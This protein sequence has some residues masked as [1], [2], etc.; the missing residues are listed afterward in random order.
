MKRL[1]IVALVGLPILFIAACASPSHPVSENT[2]GRSVAPTH[3]SAPARAAR[4]PAL[5]VVPTGIPFGQRQAIYDPL[6]RNLW[7]LTRADADNAVLLTSVASADG[8]ARTT[9]L[10]ADGADWAAGSLTMHEGRVWASW[11]THLVSFSPATGLVRAV[12]VPWKDRGNGTVGR[13]TAMTAAGKCLWIGVI[14][15][16]R[17][18]CYEPSASTWRAVSTPEGRP[19]S[20][21]TKM[22]SSGTSALVNL[23]T[24]AATPTL[25]TGGTEIVW[26]PE[27]TVP[28]A[29]ESTSTT[30]V[31]GNSGALLEGP[32]TTA[33]AA[34]SAGAARPRPALRHLARL[35]AVSG[36]PAV[37]L[38]PPPA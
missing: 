30:G 20:F 12:T 19:V 5:K 13:S 24:P 21:F 29:S 32:D 33:T 3:S 17:L 14:G 11:G 4:E 34:P 7:V 38:I 23:G 31:V 35:S 15:E 1:P 6:A 18:R 37:T 2:Y 27:N 22:A 9:K 25:P 36:R 28:V 26:V 8:A 16:P 10:S